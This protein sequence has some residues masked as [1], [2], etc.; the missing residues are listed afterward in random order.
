[1]RFYKMKDVVSYSDWVIDYNMNYKG[2]KRFG[3]HF[4]DCFLSIDNVTTQWIASTAN[5]QT[6]GRL[7]SHVILM[8]NLD[9]NKLVKVGK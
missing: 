7:I 6:A 3:Q 9:I 5:D 2:T 1:M 8:F 4:V